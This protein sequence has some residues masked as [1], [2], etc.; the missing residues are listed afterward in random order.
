MFKIK[1]GFSLIELVVAVAI[2]A[3]LAALLVPSFIHYLDDARIK[4]DQVKFDSMATAFKTAL[5][6]DEI[7][8]EV[9]RDF[10]NEEITLT[11]TI[12]KGHIDFT[13][14]ELKNDNKTVLFK[15]SKIG[16]NTYQTIG[17][18]YQMEQTKI[19]DGTLTYTLVPKQSN[20]TV[21]VA[22]ELELENE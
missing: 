3:V 18:E 14:G 15:D 2:M 22:Y 5:G 16:L 1:K 9:E 12:T 17:T 19:A 20:T 21:V 8:R 11:F 13:V 4:K 7:R 6:E 10:K